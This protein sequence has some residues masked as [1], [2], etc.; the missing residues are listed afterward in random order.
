M[1]AFGILNVLVYTERNNCDVT[2]VQNYVNFMKLQ[3]FPT[4]V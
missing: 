1:F 2:G 4:W 3:A